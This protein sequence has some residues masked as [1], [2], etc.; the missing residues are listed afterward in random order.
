MKKN[1]KFLLFIIFI[2]WMIFININMLND[3]KKMNN[4]MNKQIEN[5]NTY[6]QSGN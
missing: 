1:I 3:I 4:I 2:C 5:T 6:E